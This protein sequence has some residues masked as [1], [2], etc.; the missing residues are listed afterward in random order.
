MSI[1]LYILIIFYIQMNISGHMTRQEFNDL[2]DQAEL[3][4]KE[5]CSKVGLQYNAV[6]QW[7][8]NGRGVPI[9]VDSWLKNYIRLKSFEQIRRILNQIKLLED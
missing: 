8:S 4:K 5:F 1:F 3:S 6:N 7:G 9:W 2:L